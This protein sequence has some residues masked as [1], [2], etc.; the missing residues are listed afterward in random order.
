MEAVIVALSGRNPEN[1]GSK[2]FD[3]MLDELGFRPRIEYLKGHNSLL[4]NPI[5][6][7]DRRVSG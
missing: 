5:S 4:N 1:M 7:G 3:Q 2:D 6:K